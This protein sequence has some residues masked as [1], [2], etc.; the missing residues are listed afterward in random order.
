M[1]RQKATFSQTLNLQVCL[2]GKKYGPGISDISSASRAPLAVYQHHEAGEMMDY[3]SGSDEYGGNDDDDGEGRM[4]C[5]R[6]L[7]LH[8]VC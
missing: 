6:Q 8:M 2:D 7:Q 1:K 4:E 3:D 5:N